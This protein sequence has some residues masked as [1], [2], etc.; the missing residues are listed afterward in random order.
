M[1]AKIALFLALVMCFTAFGTSAFADAKTATVEVEDFNDG[2]LTVTVTVEDETI[3]GVEVTRSTQEATPG[4]EAVAQIPQMIIAANSADVDSV[5]GATFTSESIKTA[6]KA[7]LAELGTA[8]AAALAA[9]AE[10]NGYVKAEDYNLVVGVDAISG[11]SYKNEVGQQKENNLLTQE[12]AKQLTRDYLR[13]YPMYYH[14]AEGAD[15]DVDVIYVQSNIDLFEYLN[16]I[17]GSYAYGDK[18]T[19]P[20]GTQYT[21]GLPSAPINTADYMAGI[22]LGK[23]TEVTDEAFVAAIGP[24]EYSYREMYAIGTSYNNVPGLAQSEAVLDPES[25]LIF[26]GSNT[27]SEKSLELAANNVI[28][29]YWVNGINEKNYVAGADVK[30]NDYYHSYGVRIEGTAGAVKI[31]TVIDEDG[32]ILRPAVVR[33]GARYG[34]SIGG[35][36][37]WFSSHPDAGID[38]TSAWLAET[39]YYA[40]K[41]A[42][43]SDSDKEA[44]ALEIRG[45]LA[46]A[47][48]GKLDADSMYELDVKTL[49]DAGKEVT[50]PNLKAAVLNAAMNRSSEGYAIR[51]ASTG[52]L[53]E[54]VPDEFLTNTLWIISDC[55]TEDQVALY[56]AGTNEI[57]AKWA[58]RFYEL[59]TKLE[60]GQT[61]TQLRRQVYYAA[62]DPTLD[63]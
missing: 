8:D 61:T 50:L 6:V 24:A 29:M 62:D 39:R 16:E 20:S 34:Q 60:E 30:D 38:E 26:L 32:N 44:A 14:V 12:E 56:E 7:A 51:L 9:W 37:E 17:G 33:G 23:D 47:Y 41:W 10:A 19:G 22:Q 25:M 36:E 28:K 49:T 42:E 43:M 45:Y 27:G 35:A 53:L 2:T 15:L 11:S 57:M 59:T 46:K 55:S 63:R 54:V 5:S 58:R 52:A 21:Y 31:A 4:D 13:G 1:R 48:L 3:T 18:Y 40:D